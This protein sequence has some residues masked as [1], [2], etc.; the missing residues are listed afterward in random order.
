MFTGEGKGV[1]LIKKTQ[2]YC[3]ES[4]RRTLN[5][6]TE[7]GVSI[8]L[9]K[10]K[11]AITTLWGLRRHLFIILSESLTP[12]F[13]VESWSRPQSYVSLMWLQY[14][15]NMWRNHA[16]EISPC[17]TWN[18]DNSRCSHKIHMFHF[19]KA[20]SSPPQLCQNQ[21]LLT[22]VGRFHF[23]VFPLLLLSNLPWAINKAF[24]P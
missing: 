5:Q 10:T 6:D 18:R 17:D 8:S 12:S 2:L 9:P 7:L 3:R 24:L 23:T 21:S 4:S 1:E 14:W 11:F 13:Q 15:M 19:W 20:L 16:H 22:A